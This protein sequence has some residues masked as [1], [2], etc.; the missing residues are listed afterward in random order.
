MVLRWVSVNCIQIER[1]LCSFWDQL[2]VRQFTLGCSLLDL[3]EGNRRVKTCG[4]HDA[5]FLVKQMVLLQVQF[6]ADQTGSHFRLI[7]NGVI[8]FVL[9]HGLMQLFH[10]LVLRVGVLDNLVKQL[11]GS[12]CCGLRNAKEGC[13]Q[14]ICNVFFA[15]KS[16]TVCEDEICHHDD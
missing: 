16:L 1:K 2:S 11:A 14:F 6:V 9:T 3:R 7:K 12:G 5:S 4:F 10:N 15:S 8:S 13:N